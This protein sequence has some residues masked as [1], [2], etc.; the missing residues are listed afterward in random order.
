MRSIADELQIKGGP[1]PML[2]TFSSQVRELETYCCH[3]NTK[4]KSAQKKIKVKWAPAVATIVC[5][6]TG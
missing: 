5:P 3:I 2:V 1:R 6:G 4:F